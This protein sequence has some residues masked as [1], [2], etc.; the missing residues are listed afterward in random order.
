MGK[1]RLV[2][3]VGVLAIAVGCGQLPFS[4][5]NRHNFAP[6]DRLPESDGIVYV[7]KFVS[8]PGPGHSPIVY[9][10]KI[11]YETDAD[12]QKVVEEFDLLPCDK[13][14]AET[15]FARSTSTPPKWFPLSGVT[16][17]YSSQT[18]PAYVANLWVDKEERVMIIERSWF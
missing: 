9:L 6:W 17:L 5:G 10:A 1:T 4:S 18:D 3:C 2:Y 16:V 15:S 14:R 7:E 13:L 12:V 8:D 11:K